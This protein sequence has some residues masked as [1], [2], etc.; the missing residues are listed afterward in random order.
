MRPHADGTI[1]T[2]APRPGPASARGIAAATFAVAF[3]TASLMFD[4]AAARAQEPPPLTLHEVVEAALRTDPEL[5]A[6]RAGHRGAEADVA[7]AR[8]G[9]L[10]NVTLEGSLTRFQEPMVVAPLHSFDPAA[11]PR[12]DETL[13]QG[14]ARLRY[15]A[16]DGG[17]TGARLSAARSGAAAA[18]AGARARRMAVLERAATAY[19]E[20]LAARAH[21]DAATRR[22]EALVA[23]AERAR[24][25]AEAG[26]APEVDVLRASAALEEARADAAGAKARTEL[27]E[28]GLAR[29][30]DQPPD[31]VVDRSL[32]DITLAP[33]TDDPAPEPSHPELVRALEQ[34]RAAEAR[35]GGARAARLPRLE[36]RAGLLDY[37]TVTG[38]HVAEWQAGVTLSWPLFTGGARGAA[39]RRAEA[40]RA[41]ARQRR[42]AAERGVDRAVDAATAEIREADARESALAAS[43][44]QWEEVTRIE[45]LALDAGSGVQSDLLAAEA[46]LFRARAGLARARYDRVLARVR[47]A[48][49]RGTL[50]RDWLAR[51]LEENR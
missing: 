12:F 47:L 31:S 36:V 4:P 24:R 6:A 28:R 2:G 15:T 49:A 42:S 8:A 50:N 5:A 37:G 40:E 27:S 11:P 13:V 46:S 38:G 21:E 19:F 32:T 17:A 33:S 9:R 3:V 48:R 14:A 35:L 20:V 51:A 41:A 44:T 26:S 34:E 23:E 1:E 7:R 43:V 22:V 25:M 39:V 30:M 10:P 45:A 29:A 16:F 18:E